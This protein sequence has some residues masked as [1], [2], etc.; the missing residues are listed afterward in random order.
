MQFGGGLLVLYLWC[1][2]PP[3]PCFPP[4][5]LGG[6]SLRHNPLLCFRMSTRTSWQGQNLDNNFQQLCLVT[7]GKHL[8]NLLYLFIFL[9]F[10]SHTL[11]SPPP[12]CPFHCPHLQLSTLGLSFLPF[13][14]CTGSRTERS[15]TATFTLSGWGSVGTNTWSLLMFFLSLLLWM[16][17]VN[18]TCQRLPP[19]L[20]REKVW[21]A[22]SFSWGL[23]EPNSLGRSDLK[24]VDGCWAPHSPPSD[25]IFSLSLCPWH[26]PLYDLNSVWP[27]SSGPFLTPCGMWLFFPSD[28]FYLCPTPL[29]PPLTPSSAVTFI[30]V[31]AWDL[32]SCALC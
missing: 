18:S 3:K 22:A 8:P 29:P 13:E 30:F 1:S 25:M 7:P 21:S 11:I 19:H 23:L 9:L 28:V 20:M 15:V 32:P 24:Q 5:H 4:S 17:S 31:Y 16:Y 12:P 10:G 2:L 27:L 6:L 14:T 26:V